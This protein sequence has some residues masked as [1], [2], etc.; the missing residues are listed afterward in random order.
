[1]T[2]LN[3]DVLNFDVQPIEWKNWLSLKKKKEET[4]EKKVEGAKVIIT[5]KDT[6]NNEEV[7]YDKKG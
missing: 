7:K 3:L 5:E 6:E 2:A 1:M 4:I